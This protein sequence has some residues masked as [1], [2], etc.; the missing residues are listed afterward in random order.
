MTGSEVT[1]HVIHITA[2][3][4]FLLLVA[5]VTRSV[6]GTKGKCP[7]GKFGYRCR[8]TC[9]CV[10]GVACDSVTG[11]CPGPCQDGWSG[12]HCQR[13]N[14]VLGMP[15]DM[16]TPDW[17]KGSRAVDGDIGTCVTSTSNRTGWWRVDM[18]VQKTVF[19]MEVLFANHTARSG[20]VR[21]H[22]S[23]YVDTF[24]GKPCT[25]IPASYR[26]YQFSC[27]VPSTGRYFGIINRDGQITLCEVLVFVCAP[28]TFGV[29]CSQECACLDPSE[30]C[31][32]ITG[33]CTSGCREG[34]T[35][36]SCNKPCRGRYGRG[37][38]QVC[39]QCAGQQ[40][41]DPVSGVCSVGCAP[42]WAGARCQTACLPGTYGVDCVHECHRCLD[43]STCEPENGTCPWRCEPGWQGQRC[44]QPCGAGRYGQNCE[45]PCGHCYGTSVCDSKTGF[46]PL[47]CS[48]G[49]EGLFCTKECLPGLWGPNCLWP[50]GQCSDPACDRVTGFCDGTGCRAGWFGNTCS[51]VCLPGTYGANCQQKC[52]ACQSFCDVTDGA[53]QSSC[54]PGWEG[55]TCSLTCSNKTYGTD[56][57]SGCGH[58]AN[59]E[60]CHHISGHCLRACV[61]GYQKP[62]CQTRA[63]TLLEQLG[64]PNLLTLLVACMS[65]FGCTIFGLSTCLLLRWRQHNQQTTEPSAPAFKQTVV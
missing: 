63:E 51:Q 3:A 1:R 62:L 52:G 31:N 58:C 37:C 20:R 46:C 32:P 25:Y 8:L 42:G 54:L 60:P 5:M 40:S 4:S 18:L 47:G 53:C 39:G 27:D 2:C 45:F 14:V 22:V 12:P 7:E 9:R 21:V 15:T 55:Q 48:S 41:C 26:I 57:Q 36:T 17:S 43:N 34:L 59:G 35:G 16:K 38:R 10:R 28:Y 24:W 13:Q 23:D 65:V 56:C 61:E 64:K 30:Q 6:D 33:S 44:D 19:F 49:Y 29:D 50:C 11:Q